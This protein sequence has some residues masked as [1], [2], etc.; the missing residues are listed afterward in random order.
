MKE[1]NHGTYT[2]N[3]KH[4]D[5]VLRELCIWGYLHMHTTK[6]VDWVSAKALYFS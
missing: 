3:T 1:T 2:S 4:D 5:Q 6:S